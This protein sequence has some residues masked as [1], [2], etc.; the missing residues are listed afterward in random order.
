MIA[1]GD[2]N[3]DQLLVLATDPFHGVGR[4]EMRHSDERLRLDS[5]ATQFYLDTDIPKIVYSAPGG[6]FASHCVQASITRLPVGVAALTDLPSSLDYGLASPKLVLDVQTHWEGAP[7]DHASMSS[8]FRLAVRPVMSGRLHGNAV[9]KRLVYGGYM[10][11]HLI[12]SQV[13]KSCM[14]SFQL[15]SSSG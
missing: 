5:L 1:V 14:L 11:V 12:G 13:F 15:C 7:A 8:F 4:R 6:P 2:W 10:S 9:T 3:V